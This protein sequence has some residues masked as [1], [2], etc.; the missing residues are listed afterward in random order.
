MDKS[1]T[2]SQA[3]IAVFDR[4]AYTIMLDITTLW[5]IAKVR[6]IFCS[7]IFP[8]PSLLVLPLV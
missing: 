1:Y 4:E 3:E 7:I 6:H 2:L 5:E 8:L